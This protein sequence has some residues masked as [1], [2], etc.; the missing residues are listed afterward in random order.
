MLGRDFEVDAWSIFWR[1]NLIKFCAWTCDMTK[2]KY[3]G[4][5]NWT[6]GSIVPLAMFDIKAQFDKNCKWIQ[7]F[8]GLGLSPIANSQV[9]GSF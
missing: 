5:P 3:F 4:K 2:I 7:Q 9:H 6:L 1:W 8:I